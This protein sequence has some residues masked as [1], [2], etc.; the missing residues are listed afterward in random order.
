[1]VFVLFGAS[2]VVAGLVIAYFPHCGNLGN[3]SGP[4]LGFGAIVA[5]F[6]LV[7]ATVG[8]TLAVIGRNDPPWTSRHRVPLVYSE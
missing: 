8:L 6:G 2:S 5:I 4:S 7:M 3:C 1:M